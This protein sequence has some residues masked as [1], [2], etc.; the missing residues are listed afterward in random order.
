[1]TVAE[2]L[3][4]L[5]VEDEAITAMVIET[6]LRKAGYRVAGHATSGEEAVSLAAKQVFHVVLM[7][8]RLAGDMDGIEAAR[9]IA[10]SRR[11]PIVF[12]TGYQDE[13]TRRRAAELTPFAYLVKPVSGDD[14]ASL[15]AGVRRRGV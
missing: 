8:I 9:R 3:K 4:V 11:T 12:M 10:K 13:E 15:L 1:M 5:L 2:E 7:D 6:Q 14:L